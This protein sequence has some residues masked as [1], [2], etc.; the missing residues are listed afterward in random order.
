MAKTEISMKLIFIPLIVLAFCLSPTAAARD[1]FDRDNLVAW[2]IVPFDAKKR[3]PQQR[4]ELLEKLGIHRSA[5]DWRAEHLPT[6]ETEM[7]ELE[8]HNIEVTALW[9]P[10]ELHADARV[11]LDAHKKQDLHP[12]RC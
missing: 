6:F 5:H 10:A 2:C 8:R 12:Q 1:I 3:T 7:N 4:A 11:L 9:F